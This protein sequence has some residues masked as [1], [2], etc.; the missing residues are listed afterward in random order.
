MLE[1]WWRIL[2]EVRLLVRRMRTC[3][4]HAV[5]AHLR[6]LVLIVA[7]GSGEQVEPLCAEWAADGVTRHRERRRI[8]EQ[9]VPKTFDA[10]SDPT[11]LL[12][13]RR[14]GD[15]AREGL[16]AL[17]LVAGQDER[18]AT[19]P[20]DFCGPS[21]VSVCAPTRTSSPPSA[22]RCR[23]RNYPSLSCGSSLDMP[24]GAPSVVWTTVFGQRRSLVGILPHL[25]A[26]VPAPLRNGAVRAHR[27]Q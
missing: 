11:V 18:P 8:H 4:A 20:C 3:A 10:S 27:C 7:P 26:G 16:Q 24:G 14:P 12:R 25:V 19:L 21:A 2:P 13:H 17:A 5:R 9:P 6:G 15:L 22:G 23:A 1:C